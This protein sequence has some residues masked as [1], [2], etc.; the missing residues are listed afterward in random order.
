M[1]AA[2]PAGPARAAPVQ[3]RLSKIFSDPRNFNGTCRQKEVQR[4]V[5]T[6]AQLDS[7]NS[8]AL[9]TD[10]EIPAVLSCMVRGTAGDFACETQDQEHG[11]LLL[12]LSRN[13][14]G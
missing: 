13:I 1:L 10:K 4:M 7:R 9:P 14:S 12:S 3:P 11:R 8:A 2:A 5:D 6:C